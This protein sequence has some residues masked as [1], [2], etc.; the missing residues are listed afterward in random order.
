MLIKYSGNV[1]L[2]LCLLRVNITIAIVIIMLKQRRN[3]ILQPI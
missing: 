2:Q 3:G 1:R